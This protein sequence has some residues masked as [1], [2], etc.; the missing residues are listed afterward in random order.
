MSINFEWDSAKAATN[1]RKHGISFELAALAFADPFAFVMEERIEGDEHRWRTLGMVEGCLLL[2]VAHTVHDMDGAE[3]IRIISA[4]KATR[5][6][7]QRY[8]HENR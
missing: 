1:R 8:E 2:L 6:E 7:R 4:R 3:F 5:K